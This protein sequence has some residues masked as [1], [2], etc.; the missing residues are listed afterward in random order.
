MDKFDYIKM[1]KFLL[2]K[3]HHKESKSKSYNLDDFTS[4][5]VNKKLVSRIDK[6]LS[7]RKGQI[8]IKWSKRQ[9]RNFTEWEIKMA[10]KIMKSCSSH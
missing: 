4:Q 1:K 3:R 2:I 5:V 7:I 9:E 8:S 6:E 10:H